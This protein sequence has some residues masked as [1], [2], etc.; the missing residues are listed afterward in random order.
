MRCF[1]TP[2]STLSSEQPINGDSQ[3]GTY[4]YQC[5][6]PGL[7]V[8]ASPVLQGTVG[9]S[10]LFSCLF[11]GKAQLLNRLTYTTTYSHMGNILLTIPDWEFIVPRIENI[12]A[13]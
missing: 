11:K 5:F 3:S 6:G 10:S 4:G 7:T 12:L 9:Q 8:P 2:H 13:P 1:T